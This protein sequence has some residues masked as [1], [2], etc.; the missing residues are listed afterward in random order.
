MSEEPIKTEGAIDRDNR[1][2][3]P[4]GIP[5]TYVH[6]RLRYTLELP[7]DLAPGGE[8]D[9]AADGLERAEVVRVGNGDRAGEVA[10]AH[11]VHVHLRVG[12]GLREGEVELT[13]PARLPP[14]AEQV[15]L[16]MRALDASLDL[17]D[18]SVAELFG[19]GRTDLRAMELVS[20]R[21][22]ATCR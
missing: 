19:I 16:E 12:L 4:A 8:R 9:V 15:A 1:A 5:Y 22:P 21:G 3:L 20:R 6:R 13:Q 14:L 10:A 17:L 18:A 7:Q 11:E 2:P